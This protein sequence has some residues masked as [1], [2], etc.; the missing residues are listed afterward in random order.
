MEYFDKIEEQMHVTLQ[1]A[2]EKG[3]DMAI[4]LVR[5]RVKR[6]QTHKSGSFSP[7]SERHKKRRAN[8]G[9]Q[10]SRKDFHYSGT[11]FS[12][13]NEIDRS[14]TAEGVSITVSFKGTA[15]RRADQK[16]AR[17]IDLANWLSDYEKHSIIKLSD[18]EKQ[19][20]KKT[21]ADEFRIQI[22]NITIDD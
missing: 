6:G 12:N 9:L 8:E 17:N 4:E 19:K 15:S 21:M 13:F 11:M 16:S 3:R 14:I 7:Y 20:I 22:N 10:T 2:V 1:K 18:D 5:E